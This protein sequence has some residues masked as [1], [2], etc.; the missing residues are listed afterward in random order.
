M[1]IKKDNKQS[2]YLL[3]VICLLGLFVVVFNYY[4]FFIKNDYEVTKQIPCDPAIDSCFVSDCDSNDSTCDT[5]TTYMKI[6][7]PS[8]YAGSDYDSF[9]CTKGDPHCQIITCQDN[10]VEAGEKC[11]K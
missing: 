7:A 4:N 2:K 5:E 3:L 10:T 1:E 8:K 6:S 9:S 11:F